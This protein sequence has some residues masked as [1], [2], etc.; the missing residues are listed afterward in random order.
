[1][2]GVGTL[3]G[4]AKQQ[5]YFHVCL[6]GEPAEPVI[7]PGEWGN[8]VFV[9][10]GYKKRALFFALVFLVDL[11]CSSIILVVLFL[12]GGRVG[13]R[14]ACAETAERTGYNSARP[15]RVR[16]TNSGLKRSLCGAWAT[17]ST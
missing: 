8:F 6:A 12:L 14:A 2:V 16:L 1:M 13:K 17:F 9:S 15:L 10:S 5:Q 11:F 7:F 3:V 4:N